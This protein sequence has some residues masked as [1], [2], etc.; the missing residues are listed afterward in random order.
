[1]NHTPLSKVTSSEE[2]RDSGVGPDE[3]GSLKDQC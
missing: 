3:M 2:V 1:M